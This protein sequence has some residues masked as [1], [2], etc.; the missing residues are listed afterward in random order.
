M[1]V[2]RRLVSS[3]ALTGWCRHMA[4]GPR[5]RRRRRR[6]ADEVVGAGGGANALRHRYP[7]LTSFRRLAADVRPAWLRQAG[8]C[9]DW[10][11][12]AALRATLAVSPDI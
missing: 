3:V 2:G 10:E 11:V 7:T 9:A 1:G 6:R 12:V 4:L 8:Y 5:R